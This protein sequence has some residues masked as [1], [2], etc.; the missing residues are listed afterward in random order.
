MTASRARGTRFEQALCDYLNAHGFEYAE[1][2]ALRGTNDRGDIAGIPGVV[3]EAKAT[4]TI[5]L[6][7]AM[8][9]LTKEIANAH[10]ARGYL[11]VKRRNK[12]IDQSYVVCSL[13]QWCDT[14]GDEFA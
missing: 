14:H 7:G 12:N 13:R 1:R 11:V 6:A 8:D 2:R 5:D 9:E 3:I 4:K 10:A